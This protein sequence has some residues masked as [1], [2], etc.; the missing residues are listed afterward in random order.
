MKTFEEIEEALRN[1]SKEAYDS[2]FTFCAAVTVNND[3]GR[4][5]FFKCGR[6]LL[7][8]GLAEMIQSVTT[9]EAIK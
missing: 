4:S 6:P 1:V 5:V 9:K 2:G 3:S 8:L 7:V